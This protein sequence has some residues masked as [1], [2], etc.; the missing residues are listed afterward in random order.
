MKVNY[1][2]VEVDPEEDLNIYRNTIKILEYCWY[3]TDKFPTLTHIAV[4]MGYSER[5][6]TALARANNLPHRAQVV[7]EIKYASD[8]KSA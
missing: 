2:D 6:L 3:E 7:R 8:K 4:N 1:R 5:Q